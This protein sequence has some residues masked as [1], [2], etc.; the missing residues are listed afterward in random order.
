MAEIIVVPHTHW[1][2]E[3]YLP[4]E[5]YRYRLVKLVDELLE[6][7]RKDEEYAHFL[8]DGQVVI[9]EDY[10]EIRPEN[11]ERL[12]QEVAKGRIG[13]GPWYTMPDEFLAG[14]E[15][16]VRNLLMGHRLGRELGGVMK[17]GYLPD[18]FGHIAQ[19]PQI[20]R[21]FGIHAAFLARGV[22]PPQTEFH[23]EAPDGSKVLTHWFALGYCN[24]RCLT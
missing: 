7:L 19:M 21:G 11:E 13:I 20:L 2:R 16:I 3:W 14:G 18:P 17:I 5:R 6:I 10:L 12:R 22:D 1:D 4:F 8:L 9:A 24:A 23:W 15:A